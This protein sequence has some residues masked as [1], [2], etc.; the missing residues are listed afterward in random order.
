MLIE[1]V[2]ASVW[3]APQSGVSSSS[4][5]AFPRVLLLILLILAG[6]LVL[7][8]GK[9][10]SYVKW[11]IALSTAIVVKR[12]VVEETVKDHR[13]HMDAVAARRLSRETFLREHGEFNYNVPPVR[14][15]WSRT[16]LFSM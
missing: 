5:M 1:F 6:A 2:S 16:F 15:G 9:S 11:R 13:R 7:F 8:Y 12:K 14:S 3:A 10:L 4:V